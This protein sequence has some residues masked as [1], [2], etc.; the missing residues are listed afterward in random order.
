MNYLGHAYLSFGDAGLLTGNM[1]ADHVKGKIVLEQYPAAIKNGM[2]LHRKIDSFCDAHP[3]IRSA[4][5]LFREQY[6]LFSG[7]IVDTLFD[8]FLAN[9]P[10]IFPAKHDLAAFAQKSYQQIAANSQYLPEKFAAYFPYMVE[11]DWLTGYR[12]VK[13]MERA[14]H[15]L[16]RRS[17]YFPPVEKAFEIFITDYFELNRFYTAFIAEIIVFVK[18][19]SA[20]LFQS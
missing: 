17:I 8:H 19:E 9:D 18:F 20:V 4:K 15:G 14:L 5:L 3:V 16:R 1:I 6:G 11:H 12:N 10:V 13:S 2:L 7:P